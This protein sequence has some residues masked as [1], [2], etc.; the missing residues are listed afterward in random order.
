MKKRYLVDNILRDLDEKMVF[1]GGARQVGKTSRKIGT[2]PIF[3]TRE[4]YLKSNTMCD[5]FRNIS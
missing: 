3:L 2:A 1:I 5:T 4:F